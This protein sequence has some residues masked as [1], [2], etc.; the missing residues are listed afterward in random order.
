MRRDLFFGITVLVTVISSITAINS[1]DT[2]S[3]ILNAYATLAGFNVEL[4]GNEEV[5]PVQTD[6]TGSAEFT[7]PHF[8]NIGYSVNVSNIDKVTAAHIHSGKI[9]ENG[10]IVVTLFKT[11]TPS[12]EPIN[13]NLASGN[14]TNANLEGPMAGKTLMDLTKSMELGETYVNV[15]TEE[16]PNGEIRGQIKG[17]G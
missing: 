13:G 9:G 16:N 15:H 6:A 8:D 1:F 10:P 12:T 5:P 4:S 11:E 17:G 7:A 3:N 2:K 14:I